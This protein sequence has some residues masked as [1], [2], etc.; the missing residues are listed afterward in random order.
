MK[1]STSFLMS[2]KLSGIPAMDGKENHKRIHGRKPFSREYVELYG[3][4]LLFRSLFRDLTPSYHFDSLMTTIPH[5]LEDLDSPGNF[6]RTQIRYSK[7]DE[8]FVV[9]Y[10]Y[11]GSK[12][13]GTIILSPI[14][15]SVFQ[16]SNICDA[17]GSLIVW[18]YENRHLR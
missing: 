7:A 18:A 5:N 2:K 12:R 3:W 10:E 14:Q 1:H 4:R 9:Y 15:E 17:L 11:T 13:N 8:T 16:D 6:L